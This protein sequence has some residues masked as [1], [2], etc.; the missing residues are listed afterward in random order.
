[1]KIRKIGQKRWVKPLAVIVFAIIML[2]IANPKAT[3][4]GWL[5]GFLGN[6]KINMGLDL[7]GGVHLI[8]EA[9]M[10]NIEKG[11]EIEALR[12]VQDVIERRVNAYGVAEPNIQPSKIGSSYRLI[13]ELAG[14]KDVEEAKNLI[15]ETPLLEF[16]K[17]KEQRTELNEEERAMIEGQV[18]EISAAKT[19]AKNK[20]N[21]TL[22]KALKGDNFDSLAEEDS[23]D[24]TQGK[25]ENLGFVKKGEMVP[26]F[27][28][29]IFQDDF[30][31]NT[32][33]SEVVETQFGFHVIKK[34]SQRGDGESREVEVSHI[35]YFAQDPE[36]FRVS[37]EKQ[38]LQQPEFEST[39][40]SGKELK[41]SQVSF[42]QQL[43]QPIV[44]LQ[45]D[46]EGK[47][48]F[49][50]ITEQ[51]KGKRIAIFLDDQV[52]SAPVVNDVIR[53]GEAII[54]GSFKLQEAKDLSR[55]LNAGALPVPIHLISQ[56]SVEASLGQ[57]SLEKS[58]KAG[59]WGLAIV[60]VFMIIYYRF[61]GLIAVFALI[62]YTATI[63]A[64]YKLSS[65]SPYGV[66]LTLSGI[67][68]FILSVGMAVDANILIFERMKEE[69]KR[70]RDLRAALE[71]G[72]KRAWTSIRDG[73]VSTIL[74]SII[75]IMFGSGFIK[76]FAITLIIGVLVSMF[77]AI[78]I[79]RVLL[80]AVLFDW[81]ERHKVWMLCS[82]KNKKK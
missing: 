27:E 2:V 78:V 22:E 76:G 17:E 57:A 36:E 63:V 18:I 58:L 53:D 56:Q 43:G 20:A 69:I 7:Q 79:T 8:Y 19:E 77:T 24:R 52:I 35:L 30:A 31:E 73:N 62:I 67:A 66:T 34:L 65:L 59:L 29:A 50:E 82:G 15:K 81:L 5:D 42:D 16:K 70:G 23:E 74:T 39:G 26:E 45:F 12:G 71:E 25:R 60:G 72:F 47:E 28:E 6:M 64:I 38:I 61:A 1:M 75:L 10:E 11:E 21:E 41:R 13:V 54:S 37:I 46:D 9:D 33:F 3:G 55:R 49:K 14:I 68:G 40:L 4:I 32:I 44:V 80:G 48:L 51:N